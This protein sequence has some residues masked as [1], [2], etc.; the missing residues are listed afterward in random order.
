MAKQGPQQASENLDKTLKIILSHSQMWWLS[1][2]DLQINKNQE[3]PSLE[4][5]ELLAYMGFE[6][7]AAK[8]AVRP[9]RRN[10]QVVQT[11]DDNEKVF[12]LTYST[13]WKILHQHHQC[14]LQI[15]QIQM[16]S[17]SQTDEDTEAIKDILD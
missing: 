13:K 6:A 9:F 16:F 2:S 11:L 14:R 5:I 17:A 3:S 12:L 8:A 7:V 10:V 15:M 4:N 1:D